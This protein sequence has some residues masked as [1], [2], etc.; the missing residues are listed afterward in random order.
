[1]HYNMHK[2]RFTQDGEIYECKAK[3]RIAFVHALNATIRKIWKINIDFQ[4][5]G[6]VKFRN[7]DNIHKNTSN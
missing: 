6:Y 1:M 3:C 2:Y 4:R 7:C 5:S